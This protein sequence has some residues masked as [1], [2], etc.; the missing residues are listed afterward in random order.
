MNLPVGRPFAR[1]D[2]SLLAA[3]RSIPILIGY[4]STDLVS[5]F[6]DHSHPPESKN[7]AKKSRHRSCLGG[8]RAYFTIRKSAER[9][10]ELSDCPWATH[11]VILAGE[12][13]IPLSP[14]GDIV[15]P[16]DERNAVLVTD[17]HNRTAIEATPNGHICNASDCKLVSGGQSVSRRSNKNELLSVL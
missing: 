12:C 9:F 16:G 3:R 11:K 14:R 13:E 17:T 10:G 7:T 4:Q 6:G 1:R 15:S 2:S 5:G 8:L